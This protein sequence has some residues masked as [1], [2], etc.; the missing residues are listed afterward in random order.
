[1]S[2]KYYIISPLPEID[3][4][5]VDVSPRPELKDIHSSNKVLKSLSSLGSY[6]VSPL[7]SDDYSNQNLFVPSSPDLNFDIYNKHLNF[8]AANPSASSYHDFNSEHSDLSGEESQEILNYGNNFHLFRQE[9]Y[10]LRNIIYNNP[11]S[12]SSWFSASGALGINNYFAHFGDDYLIVKLSEDQPIIPISLNSSSLYEEQQY[13][14]F[15]ETAL[16]DVNWGNISYA[17]RFNS[18]FSRSWFDKFFIGPYSDDEGEFNILSK[19]IADCTDPQNCKLKFHV[20]A[21]IDNLEDYK[22]W[23]SVNF[24]NSEKD[25]LDNDYRWKEENIPSIQSSLTSTTPSQSSTAPKVASL[26]RGNLSYSPDMCPTKWELAEDYDWVCQDSTIKYSNPCPVTPT[27]FTPTPES[28]SLAEV[29]GEKISIP[30]SISLDR[31]DGSKFFVNVYEDPMPEEEGE[32][33]DRFIYKLL[34]DYIA[35]YNNLSSISTTSEAVIPPGEYGIKFKDK[36]KKEILA[37]LG[38][39]LEASVLKTTLSLSEIKEKLISSAKF[40]HSIDYKNWK[41]SA[42]R[43]SRD[44]NGNFKPRPSDYYN[45]VRDLYDFWLKGGGEHMDLQKTLDYKNVPT[46]QNKVVNSIKTISVED[47]NSNKK[48]PTIYSK[49][50]FNEAVKFGYGDLDHAQ[51]EDSN[52]ISIQDSFERSPTPTPE[53]TPTITPYTPT[54]GIIEPLVQR[55]DKTHLASSNDKSVHVIKEDGSLWM[56]SATNDRDLEYNFPYSSKNPLGEFRDTFWEQIDTNVEQVHSGHFGTWYVKSEVNEHGDYD[57]NIYQSHVGNHFDKELVFEAGSL[58]VVDFS[59]GKKHV[60]FVLSNGSLWGFGFNDKGQLG[61]PL[62]SAPEPNPENNIFSDPVNIVPAPVSTF[63][64][65]D[66]N[67]QEN[68]HPFGVR[69]CAAGRDCS[70]FVKSDLRHSVDRLYGMGYSDHLLQLGKDLGGSSY[71]PKELVPVEKLIIE[72]HGQITSLSLGY[73]ASGSNFSLTTGHIAYSTST[74]RVYVAGDN[75]FGQLGIALEGGPSHSWE[76]VNSYEHNT[77]LGSVAF[78]KVIASGHHTHFIS[79]EK[80]GSQ[81]YTC[82]LADNV[83]KYKRNNKHFP[84]INVSSSTGYIFSGASDNASK[85]IPGPTPAL[86]R[87]IPIGSDYKSYN[88]KITKEPIDYNFQLI[89]SPKNTIVVNIDSGDIFISGNSSGQFLIAMSPYKGYN[90]PYGFNKDSYGAC[91]LTNRRVSLSKNSTDHSTIA[92]TIKGEIDDNGGVFLGESHGQRSVYKFL[93]DYLEYFDIDFLCLEI[94]KIPSK[95]EFNSA[96]AVEEYQN[97]NFGQEDSSRRTSL[98]ACKLMSSLLSPYAQKCCGASYLFPEDPFS[99]NPLTPTPDKWGSQGPIF[100]WNFHSNSD[101]VVYDAFT[102]ANS[103]TDLIEKATSLGIKIICMDVERFELS[104]GSIYTPN[105]ENTNAHWAEE[106]F[107][108]L[109]DSPNSRFIAHGGGN[110]FDPIKSFSQWLPEEATSLYDLKYHSSHSYTSVQAI[111]ASLMGKKRRFL[112][113]RFENIDSSECSRSDPSDTQHRNG[114]LNGYLVN[115]DFNGQSSDRVYQIGA[116]HSGLGPW[117][118]A[119]CISLL[120]NETLYPSVD[121]LNDAS[122]TRNAADYLIYLN[123]CQQPDQDWSLEDVDGNSKYLNYDCSLVTPDVDVSFC[124]QPTPTL[125]PTPTPTPTTVDLSS[126]PTYI[127]NHIKDNLEE[128]LFF[129][130]P[131][132]YEKYAQIKWISDN[133]SDIGVNRL[134]VELIDSD[135]QHLIDSYKNP[136][137]LLNGSRKNTPE[138][139]ALFNYI[140]KAFSFGHQDLIASECISVIDS[141]FS[142]KIKVIAIGDPTPYVNFNKDIPLLSDH[143]LKII[144]DHL[145]SYPGAKF[146]VWAPFAYSQTEEGKKLSH[147]SLSFLLKEKGFRMTSYDWRSPRYNVSDS[148]YPSFLIGPDF[149][150]SGTEYAK[151]YNSPS[152]HPTSLGA[153]ETAPCMILS[154]SEDL[155]ESQQEN[156]KFYSDFNIFTNFNSADGLNFVNYDCSLVDPNA[157]EDVPNCATCDTYLSYVDCHSGKYIYECANLE[158]FISLPVSASEGLKLVYDYR[159]EIASASLWFAENNSNVESHGIVIAPKVIALQLYYEIENSDVADWAQ[160]FVVDSLNFDPEADQS[161]GP[162]QFQPQTLAML[163]DQG[164][165]PRVPG[166]VNN[167]NDKEELKSLYNEIIKYQNSPMMIAAYFQRI[168]DIWAEGTPEGQ[169]LESGKNPAPKNFNLQGKARNALL[170]LYILGDRPVHDNPQPSPQYKWNSDKITEKSLEIDSILSSSPSNFNPFWIHQYIGVQEI[171]RD[172]NGNIMGYKFIDNSCYRFAGVSYDPFKPYGEHVSFTM[173]RPLDFCPNSCAETPTITSTPTILE[174]I[175]PVETSTPTETP[176]AP[177]IIDFEYERKVWDGSAYIWETIQQSYT[178]P[179][180]PHLVQ[181]TS[182]GNSA[183][184]ND[185]SSGDSML[186]ENWVRN[187]QVT[188]IP[189]S[190]NF[191]FNSGSPCTYSVEITPN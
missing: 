32:K 17:E 136:D 43:S 186:V 173:P 159:E 76:I 39:N 147:P 157:V 183:L 178:D 74:G 85:I 20:I 2:E 143:F 45:I 113:F 141:C 176:D 139:C 185:L 6:K 126:D 63:F 47:V 69:L 164:Y 102:G 51:V 182:S 172:G 133:I 180:I 150:H 138:H 191:V 5:F 8:I 154:T 148:D 71:S 42:G 95:G 75:S 94:K 120:A 129:G 115:G 123:N 73:D 169:V 118:N 37:W 22:Q 107:K 163:V 23:V 33:E 1:M 116:I 24:S 103:V 106:I 105:L 3:Y 68:P 55:E 140:K 66:G 100:E 114:E 161:Y 174:P 111:L 58:K 65:S 27:P 101:P 117:E 70:A 61:K 90:D 125:T 188:N 56:S 30:G 18:Y 146:I 25:S 78:T 86:Q 156:Q 10:S 168:I 81:I 92:S 57:S 190:L 171:E 28:V 11:S 62:G 83:V 184:C 31:G 40:R 89:C 15:F 7:E 110:H 162:A 127:L 60:L 77:Y 26:Y 104:T 179:Q 93:T 119:P 170:T 4:N 46:L 124:P 41:A 44:K 165:Y 155:S 53:P 149:D 144:T 12:F 34:N 153:H 97:I 151:T 82:G 108:H 152:G 135:H 122:I 59:V 142:A 54:P 50:V 128:G 167:I 72:N 16:S 158:N 112:N 79:L 187:T 189:C 160:Q 131:S 49:A 166:Y 175:T 134:F 181:L 88:A 52:A 38:N 177:L 80:N 98:A 91:L 14:N 137:V 21:S 96:L 145:N 67:S 35:F 29:F 48:D 130:A 109:S 87:E 9:D 84:T 99:S 13:L 19:S 121:N 132:A 64:D 36:N